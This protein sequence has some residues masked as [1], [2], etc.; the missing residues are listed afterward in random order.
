[1]LRGDGVR[2]DAILET[3]GIRHIRVRHRLGRE[4]LVAAAP[5]P[6]VENHRV[7]E[8]RLEGVT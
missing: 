6:R 2:A 8:A 7:R 4:L 1:M 5:T 3:E